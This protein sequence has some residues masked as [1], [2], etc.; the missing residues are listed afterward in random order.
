MFSNLYV[1]NDCT[2]IEPE[3]KYYVLCLM[4]YVLCLIQ[5]LE[6]FPQKQQEQ[7]HKQLGF[8]GKLV[9]TLI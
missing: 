2:A 4:S 8:T 6:Y 5:L 3:I 9:T 7:R 1:N